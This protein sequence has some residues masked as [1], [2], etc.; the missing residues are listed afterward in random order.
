[1]AAMVRAGVRDV[2]TAAKH[3]DGVPIVDGLLHMLST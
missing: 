1:M 2:A 3:R